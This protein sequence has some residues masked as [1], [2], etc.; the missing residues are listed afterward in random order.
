MTEIKYSKAV[1]KLDEI[2]S[3]IE[4]EQIDVDEL[5]DNVKEAVE[6]LKVCKNKI[7]KAQLDVKKVVDGFASD[8]EKEDQ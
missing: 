4:T 5:A 7:E 1:K 8:D 6:L 2:L 3:K